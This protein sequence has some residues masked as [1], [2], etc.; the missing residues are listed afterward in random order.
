M[1]GLCHVSLGNFYDA[2]KSETKAIVYSAHPAVQASP[3]FIKAHYIRGEYYLAPFLMF[4]GE[5]R[6]C[7][8]EYARYLYRKIDTRIDQL[9]VDADLCDHLKEG[10]LKALPFDI[11]V[12]VVI[13]CRFRASF[14]FNT[15]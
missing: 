11:Q 12:R 9:D 3:E 2:V 6:S 7:F 8:A 15:R 4:L 5:N 1:E 13:N 10:W 14:H